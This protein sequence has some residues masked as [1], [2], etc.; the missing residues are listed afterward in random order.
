MGLRLTWKTKLEFGTFQISGHSR[1]FAEKSTVMLGAVGTVS[2][3][4]RRESLLLI[5]A[6]ARMTSFHLAF[7]TNS[8]L[9]KLFVQ[10]IFVIENIFLN[11]AQ[12]DGSPVKRGLV[13]TCDILP[14]IF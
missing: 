10:M 12:L 8:R 7:G 4:R 9:P 3:P 14:L 5:L 1:A 13:E 2:F 6:F 11:L